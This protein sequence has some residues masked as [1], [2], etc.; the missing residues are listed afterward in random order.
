MTAALHATTPVLH[1]VMGSNA[2]MAGGTSDTDVVRNVDLYELDALDLTSVSGLI[3]NG[4]CDQ[5][6]LE[7]RKD[8]LTDFVTA[9]GR[10]AIM[11][12]PLTDFLPGLGQWRKLQY[13]GPKDLAISA[14]SPHPVWAGVDPADLSF[15][16]QVSGFYGRGYSQKLPD[17]AIVTNY[18]GRHGLP[19]DYVYPLGKGEVLVHGGIDL[20]VFQS[21]PNT[22]ARVYPQLLSWLAQ[23]DRTENR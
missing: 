9:G 21:D 18:I 5:I 3:V 12:H 14:G 8:V 1:F 23:L 20:A 6:Y 11:G 13:S 16:K 15:R 17:N 10:I 7:R 22:S 19:V 2:G 4:N